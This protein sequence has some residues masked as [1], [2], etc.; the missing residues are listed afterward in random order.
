MNSTGWKRAALAAMAAA[1]LAGSHATLA[2]AQAPSPRGIT[3]YEDAKTGALYRKPGRGRTPVVLGFDEPAAP[4]ATQQQVQQ[5][6]KR[7][8]EELRAEFNASQQALIQ[9]NTQLQA[10]V[11]KIEPAWTDYLANFR[12]RFHVGALVYTSYKMY[13]HTGFGPAQYDNNTWPGPGNNIYNTFDV[14]RAYLNFYFNPTPDWTLRVT[15]DIYK[16]FGTATPTSNSHN[17][18]VSSNLTGD[19]GYRLKYAYIEYNKI[20]DWASPALK[21]AAIQMGSIP[22]AFLPWEEEL[23]TFRY[24]TSSPWNYTGLSTTQL[25]VGHQR[26][27]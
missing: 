2:F 8:N 12:D 17:S 23:T 18:S 11:N 26:S 5:D 21:G 25:G 19:L 24:V 1:M 9:Q 14:D 13:T 15:P 20:L 6:L 4:V 7:N 10:R 22:N 16:T 27:G 3:L